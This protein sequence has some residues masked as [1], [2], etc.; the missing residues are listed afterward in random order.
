MKTEWA[1]TRHCNQRTDPVKT[2]EFYQ[3]SSRR[4]NENDKPLIYNANYE[5]KMLSA[6]GHL[7]QAGQHYHVGEAFADKRV[8][9]D[10]PNPRVINAR[11]N[12][13]SAVRVTAA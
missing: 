1:D 11:V 12:G 5:V 8:G 3:P 4:F 6:N 13:A 9:R 10:H 7:A 2:A